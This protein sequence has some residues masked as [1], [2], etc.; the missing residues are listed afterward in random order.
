[1]IELSQR[2]RALPGYPLAEI[3]TLKRRLL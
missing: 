3:P 2:L 1:M